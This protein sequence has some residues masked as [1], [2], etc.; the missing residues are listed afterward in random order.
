VETIKKKQSEDYSRIHLQQKH[1]L[2][3]SFPQAF[4]W[5]SAGKARKKLLLAVA[6]NFPVSY[7]SEGFPETRTRGIGRNF[8][9]SERGMRIELESC[10]KVQPD[11]E[12][13]F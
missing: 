11:R 4:S 5:L 12:L 13:I 6:A 9:R 8:D 7:F 2:G 10:S 3:N 1:K